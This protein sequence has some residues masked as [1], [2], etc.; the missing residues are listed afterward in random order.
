MREMF[1]LP[2]ADRRATPRAP[3]SR[4]GPPMS[5]RRPCLE[6]PPRQSPRRPAKEAT[7]R[8]KAKV[9]AP[10]PQPAAKKKPPFRAFEERWERRDPQTVCRGRGATPR[11]VRRPR[12]PRRRRRV[13]HLHGQPGVVRRRVDRARV[14][15]AEEAAEGGARGYAVVAQLRRMIAHRCPRARCSGNKRH[16]VALSSGGADRVGRA[17]PSN[18]R[19]DV[20]AT[21]PFSSRHDRGGREG[22]E[23]LGP[24]RRRSRRPARTPPSRPA[25]RSRGSCRTHYQKT[26]SF[27]ISRASKQEPSTMSSTRNLSSSSAAHAGSSVRLL[28]ATFVALQSSVVLSCRRMSLAAPSKTTRSPDCASIAS[29]SGSNGAPPRQ[30]A[31]TSRDPT[32]SRRGQTR[33]LW[34]SL[35]RASACV[36]PSAAAGRRCIAAPSLRSSACDRVW[37]AAAMPPGPTINLRASS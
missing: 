32:G 3:R 26:A 4:R 20:V 17:A 23:R 19:A 21:P 33:L 35:Q 2:A 27:V 29:P 25:T 14:E 7:P 12:V 31:C 30:T 9:E 16:T 15:E 1:G 6:L 28:M 24:R 37:H 18:G 11:Q 13:R 36:A 22:R 10:P 34:A 5:P 8:K